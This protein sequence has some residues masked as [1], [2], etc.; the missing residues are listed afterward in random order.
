[1]DSSDHT[2]YPLFRFIP[3]SNLPPLSHSDLE[4]ARHS[5]DARTSGHAA[6]RY[7]PELLRDTSHLAPATLL[8]EKVIPLKRRR[9]SPP[10][11]STSNPASSNKAHTAPDSPNRVSKPYL[12]LHSKRARTHPSKGHPELKFT[13]YTPRHDTEIQG[14]YKWSGGVGATQASSGDAHLPPRPPCS[15][16]TQTL[17][18]GNQSN[19]IITESTRFDTTALQT[20]RIQLPAFKGVSSSDRQN[21][22]PRLRFPAYKGVHVPANVR[23]QFPK[24]KVPHRWHIKV[25]GPPRPHQENEGTLKH[26]RQ[27][28]R[29][30]HNERM[31]EGPTRQPR[32]PRLVTAQDDVSYSK[33]AMQVHISPEVI[34]LT[35]DLSSGSQETDDNVNY[36]YPERSLST[37]KGKLTSEIEY[38]DL[39]EEDSLEAQEVDTGEQPVSHGSSPVSWGSRLETPTDSDCAPRSNGTAMSPLMHQKLSERD[40]SIAKDISVPF[41]KSI[42]VNSSIGL[43]IEPAKGISESQQ[44]QN[45]NLTRS[46]SVSPNVAELG[47]RSAP[48]CIPS[49]ASPSISAPLEL[50]VVKKDAPQAAETQRCTPVKRPHALSPSSM[51]VIMLSDSDTDSPS[52]TPEKAPPEIPEHLESCF[53]DDLSE[54]ESSVEEEEEPALSSEEY[55][56]A[57]E[58]ML[59]NYVSPLRFGRGNALFLSSFKPLSQN[60]RDRNDTL[61]P[62]VARSR[63]AICPLLVSE[64]GQSCEESPKYR[65]IREREDYNATLTRLRRRDRNV[66]NKGLSGNIKALIEG[67]VTGRNSGTIRNQTKE[68]CDN[69]LWV[70]KLVNGMKGKNQER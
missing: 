7:D 59:G 31:S 53:G 10:T 35:D 46:A 16:P 26:S 64:G 42:P 48:I 60:G 23:I 57:R 58:D 68:I 40:R 62:S 8:P 41:S 45:S 25:N 51:S 2:K 24:G 33:N 18:Y 9:S 12:D 4:K 70:M 29:P 65:S 5:R 47:T 37:V 67:G 49:S 43:Y 56:S 3:S 55:L 50:D 19:E 6:P 36:P 32:S 1:M 30:P 28:I 61:I 15:P 44:K 34:E 54:A 13:A 52:P 63:L 69:G 39:E 11:A 27:G 14:F 38:I 20:P 66:S 21:E 22:P 17:Y